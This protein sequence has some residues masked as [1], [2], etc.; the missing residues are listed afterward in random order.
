MDT[1]ETSIA[2]RT[3]LAAGFTIDNADRH[4]SHIEVDCARADLFGI[5]VRYRCCIFD[6]DSPPSGEATRLADTASRDNRLA[7]VISKTVGSECLAWSEFLDGLGGAVPSWHAL[8]PDFRDTF[9]TLARNE[10][11]PGSDEEPWLAFEEATADAFEFLLGARVIRLGGKRRGK[12]VSDLVTRIPDRRVLVID[13][14]AYKNPF[15]ASSGNLRALAEYTTRQCARQRGQ[16]QVGGAIVV[17][18]AFAQDADGLRRISG[19][20]LADVRVPV[21]FVTAQT[22]ADL[23]ETLVKDPMLRSAIRWGYLFCR[24]GLLEPT[25]VT[26]ELAD[27]ATERS[28]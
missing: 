14:K 18:N 19:D 1:P 3:L 4:G 12:K 7:I 6:A 26:A 10:R 23:V 5:T 2:V 25:T 17:A 28:R 20:F 8:G 15:D 11:P 21:T 16:F 22:L 27:A 9:L 13:T 24:G